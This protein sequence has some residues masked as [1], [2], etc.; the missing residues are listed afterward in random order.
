MDEKFKTKGS[1]GGWGDKEELNCQWEI[2][3]RQEEQRLSLA[4][5]FILD[6]IVAPI[7][8]F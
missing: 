3:V 8:S 4:S 1:D 7:Y 2:V 6:F 5:G